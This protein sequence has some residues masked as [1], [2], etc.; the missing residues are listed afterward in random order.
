MKSRTL[1]F[2]LGG[3]V[4]LTVGIGAF[5]W[6]TYNTL[7]G[8]SQGSDAQW[9]Q[10]Q[11]QLQRRFDLIPNLVESVKGIFNQERAVFDAIAEA[12]T[13]YSGAQD[14]S[15]KARA[16]GQVESALSRLLVVVE[17]YPEI[18]SQQNVTQLMDELAG[19]ENR[20]AVERGRYNTTVLN[21]NNAVRRFPSNIVAGMFGFAPRIYFEAVPGAAT[22]PKVQF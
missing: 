9:A 11:T 4:A 3:I 5:F 8:T 12:R 6:T 10:V 13:R 14:V 19:T 17:N 22:P 1:L 15:Q 16:A 20:I 18:R 7:V 2:I 21:Y